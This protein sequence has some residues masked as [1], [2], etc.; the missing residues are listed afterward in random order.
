[1]A[2]DRVIN[3]CFHGIGTPARE[4]EPGEDRYWVTEKQYLEILDE[5]AT[6]P[7]VRISF[8]DGNAS[9]HAIGLPA[10]LSR[11]LTA[12]FFALAAR[13][14]QPGSLSSTAL[15]ELRDAGM[16]I[17]THGM[18]HRSWRDLDP[19]ER[20]DELVSARDRLAEVAGVP[21]T[22]AACPLGRYDRTLIADMRSLG[23][24]RLF[25]SD[26]RV[27]RR[28]AWMQPRFSVRCEDTVASMREQVLAPAPIKR[29]A[30]DTAVGVI[31]RW[32]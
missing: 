31:K 28:S 1:M 2:D 8:D 12:D 7:S 30:R 13:L 19:Q 10:L 3:V 18:H 22:Q 14:D 6:W 23:Y 26:R 5:I 29:R 21:V 4:L 17:G 9:D 16:Q 11:G 32:R 15:C 25:T 27:A 24:T 20:Q